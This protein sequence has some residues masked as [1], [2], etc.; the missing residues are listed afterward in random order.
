ML[1]I[2]NKSRTN[3]SHH[4]LNTGHAYDGIENTMEFLNFQ[5]K[6]KYLNTLEWFHI[7]KSKKTVWL[8]NDNYIDTYN[9]VFKL[10]R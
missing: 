3:F 10:I 8:L 4:I 5:E 9:L 2:Y 7:Y 6:G 1:V